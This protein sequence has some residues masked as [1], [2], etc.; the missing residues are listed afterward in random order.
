MANVNA[1]IV[2][3]GG[4]LSGVAATAKA[5]ANTASNKTLALIV[6][7]PVDHNGSGSCLG[8]IATIGGQNFFD[9]GWWTAPGTTNNRDCPHR[10]TFAWWFGQMGQHYNTAALANLLRSDL[11]KYEPRL[12]IYYGYDI[13]RVNWTAPANITSVQ[14]QQID[15]DAKGIVQWN[16]TDSVTTITGSVFI[17]ASESGRLTQ[18]S[19]FGGTVGRYDWP[20]TYLDADERG[21]SGIGHQQAATLMFKVRGINRTVTVDATFSDTDMNGVYSG[22][23]GVEAYKTKKAIL[24]FNNKYGPDGFALKPF[25][26]AQD[27]P[28]GNTPMLEKEW[29]VNMLLV[30]NVDGRAYDRDYGT[31]IFPK[32]KDH[33]KTVDQAWVEAKSMLEKPEFLP[34]LRSFPGFSQASLV[35]DNQK[36]PVVGQILYLRETIHSAQSSSARA[37]G[38]ENT[39]YAI[40]TKEVELAGDRVEAGED[41]TN[42]YK[43]RIGLNKYPIDINAYKFE[44]LKKDGQ[45][46]WGSNVAENVR[47][48]LKKSLNP[49]YVPFDAI[50]TNFMYN[51]LICGYAASISSAAWAS[52]RTLPNQCVL[53]DAAGIAAAYAVTNNKMPLTFGTDTDIRTIQATL[54]N[55]KARLDKE[56]TYYPLPLKL[57]T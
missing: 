55:S 30:Y 10:G 45:F 27:G 34:A 2:I 37:N 18:L 54:K 17:D 16:H 29:W 53:G 22:T 46:V 49:Y 28:E 57:S 13:T 5:A 35:L 43:R 1:D 15:R 8:S 38:T 26:I 7:D 48:D 33:Y 14:I 51:L 24:D 4:S 12:T 39:N 41:Y 25:N 47:G 32:M 42:N 6:P 3:Y 56:S 9:V 36:K 21:P 52:A 50:A 44:D 23:G 40:S 11:K 31:S 19:N 20:S